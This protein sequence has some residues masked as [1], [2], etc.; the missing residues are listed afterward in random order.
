MRIAPLLALPL[1]AACAGPPRIPFDE[2][3]GW[4]VSARGAERATN[5]DFQGTYEAGAIEILLPVPGTSGWG[6]EFG[7]SW[8]SSSGDDTEKIHVVRDTD[9]DPNMVHNV[10][11]SESVPAHRESDI[12]EISIGVRQT[13]FPESIVQPYFGVGGSLYKTYNTDHLDLTALPP[14]PPITNRLSEVEHF[15]T[16]D[17]ALYMR[18]G[19]QWR[20]LRDQIRKD[21]EVLL[22]FDVRGSI[23]H[24]FS[25]VEFSLGLGYGR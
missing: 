2:G 15:Q 10:A 22:S 20:I 25:F 5:D 7:A 13:Y 6:W 19:L 9:P 1:V 12:Y 21:S 8:G 11:G 14:T 17:F 3:P 23:G 18:T 24:E 16:V 4:H